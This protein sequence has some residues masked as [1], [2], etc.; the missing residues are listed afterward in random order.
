MIFHCSDS[1]LSCFSLPSPTPVISTLPG[2]TPPHSE[3]LTPDLA[4]IVSFT[5]AKA[6]GFCFGFRC[7]EST[8]S[9]CVLDK[10]STTNSTHSP[11]SVA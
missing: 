3:S 8:Q 2:L 4:W 5:H 7:W 6:F 11:Q 1:V 10:L 9:L